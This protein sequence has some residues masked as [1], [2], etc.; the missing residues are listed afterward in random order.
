MA[1]SNVPWITVTGDSARRGSGTVAFTVAENTTS[2][3]RT[4]TMTIAGFTFTVS[5]KK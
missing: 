1:V 4:G 5:Q 3:A 2:A